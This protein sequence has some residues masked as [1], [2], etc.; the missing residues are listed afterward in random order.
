[1]S[2]IQ[3][4]R[5]AQIWGQGVDRTGPES[6]RRRK[7]QIELLSMVPLP[8]IDDLGMRKLPDTATDDLL[9]MMR[10]YERASTLIIFEQ[11]G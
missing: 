1:M 6:P 10:R 4:A 11:T 7:E 5:V 3:A 9:E 2:W 8:I